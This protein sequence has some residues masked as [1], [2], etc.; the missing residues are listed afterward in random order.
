MKD[1]FGVNSMTH[2][3]SY[4]EDAS[5]QVPALQ[6]QIEA[7]DRQIDALVYEPGSLSRRI[8]AHGGGRRKAGEGEGHFGRGLMAV[9]GWQR[10][11]LRT[12]K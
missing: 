3:P 6:R 7:M 4:N 2:N 5:S 11:H 9:G 8:P 1:H 12:Y 10:I